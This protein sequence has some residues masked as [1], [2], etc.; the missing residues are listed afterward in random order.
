MEEEVS[1]AP[2]TAIRR[3]HYRIEMIKLS[4]VAE[5]AVV[6]EKNQDMSEVPPH[7]INKYL[8]AQV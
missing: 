8:A 6:A 2:E 7:L 1:E 5:G 4:R 3:Q